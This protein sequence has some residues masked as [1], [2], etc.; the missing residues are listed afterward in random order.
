MERKDGSLPVV[1][2]GE[3][4]YPETKALQ[5]VPPFLQSELE[6]DVDLGI[7]PRVREPI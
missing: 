3:W 4:T 7:S 2:A 5:I 6:H 1:K